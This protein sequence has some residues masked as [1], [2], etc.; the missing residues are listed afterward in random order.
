MKK[1]NNEIVNEILREYE[2][3]LEEYKQ[4]HREH[5]KFLRN[6]PLTL[7]IGQQMERAY[8]REMF[9]EVCKNFYKRKE[10][11]RKRLLDQGSSMSLNENDLS[12]ARENTYKYESFQKDSKM[13]KTVIAFMRSRG[14][15]DGEIAQRLYMGMD[16]FIVFDAKSMEDIG[17]EMTQ[18]AIDEEEAIKKRAEE[19]K[20]RFP[21]LLSKDNDEMEPPFEN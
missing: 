5:R 13:K 7:D 2:K 21:E 4:A 3:E 19:L 6:L 9:S 10:Y 15:T 17:N 11:Y 8:R 16:E 12:I 20:K 14:F 18:A 1:K